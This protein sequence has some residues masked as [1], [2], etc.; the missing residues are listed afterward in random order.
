MGNYNKNDRYDNQSKNRL[1]DIV[2]KHFNTAI[3]G[4]LAAFE[5]GF[6]DLW[7]HFDYEEDLTETQ[8]KNEVI[9]EKIRQE[10]LDNGNHKKRLALEE[11]DNHKISW[12]RY[13]T[14]FIINKDRG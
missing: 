2:D 5:N 10:I 9:W 1:K 3:I 13:K 14:E 7:G 8:K 6:G 12:N 4:A 11:I